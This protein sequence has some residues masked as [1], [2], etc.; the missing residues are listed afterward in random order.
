MIKMMLAMGD[1]I[2]AY[3]TAHHHR[4]VAQRVR[5]LRD[6]LAERSGRDLVQLPS[7]EEMPA[8]DAAR[9]PAEEPIVAATARPAL[10]SMPGG[11]RESTRPTP[12]RSAR[13]G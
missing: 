8:R 11:N 5:D 10:K 12:V 3:E 2:R 9:L 7:R 6:K 1:Y 4:L 13:A